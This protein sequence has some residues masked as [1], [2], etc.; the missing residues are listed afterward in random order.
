MLKLRVEIFDLAISKL[1][2]GELDSGKKS[3]I[4]IEVVYLSYLSIQGSFS[5]YFQS[6]LKVRNLI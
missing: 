1:T 6:L 4:T 2:V 3:V 5:K